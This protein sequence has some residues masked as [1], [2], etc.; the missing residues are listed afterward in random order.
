M[1]EHE[2]RPMSSSEMIRQAREDLASSRPEPVVPDLETEV[3]E[4]SIE[5]PSIEFD[6]IERRIEQRPRPAPAPRPARRPAPRLERRPPPQP[7]P[8]SDREP[9]GARALA[10]V[11]GIL[12]ALI[13]LGLVLAVGLANGGV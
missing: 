12:V 4:L 2:Q 8:S 7:F 10:L 3:P 13:A 1:A 11:A 5:M 6:A 9:S